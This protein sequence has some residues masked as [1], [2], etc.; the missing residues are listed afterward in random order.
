MGCVVGVQFEAVGSPRERGS[1]LLFC[2]PIRS[3]RQAQGPARHWPLDKEGRLLLPRA[4]VGWGGVGAD[5]PL[6]CSTREAEGLRAQQVQ[7]P[8]NPHARNRAATHTRAR[9]PAPAVVGGAESGVAG[10]CVCPAGGRK[11]RRRRHGRHG[12]VDGAAALRL[13]VVGQHRR[14]AGDRRAG[15]AQRAA[16]RRLA[17]LPDAAACGCCQ[18]RHRKV[19]MWVH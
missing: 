11:R 9:A 19:G 3:R 2:A 6:S 12:R 15:V 17:A 18:Q 7:H 16:G 8:A 10:S 14:R 5:K 13:A 4:G 1:N